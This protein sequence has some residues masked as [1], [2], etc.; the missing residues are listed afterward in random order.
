MKKKNPNDTTMR[1]IAALKKRI[2]I[3]EIKVRNQATDIHHIYTG[4]VRIVRQ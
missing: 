4:L 1:N 3:L 2:R